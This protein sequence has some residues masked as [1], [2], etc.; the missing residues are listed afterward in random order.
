MGLAS[1]V[2]EVANHAKKVYRDD[3]GTLTK[4]RRTAMIDELGDVLWYVSQCADDL[5]VTLDEV[6]LINIGKLRA[7]YAG[8]YPDVEQPR[9]PGSRPDG[10]ERHHAT[11]R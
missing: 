3:G 7:R 5:G 4:G 6:A 1:E 9:R 10:R 2:G 8:S 11:R